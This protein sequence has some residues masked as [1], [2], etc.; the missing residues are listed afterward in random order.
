MRIDAGAIEI[1]I[2]LSEQFGIEE[3]FDLLSTLVE[4]AFAEHE[5][6]RQERFPQSV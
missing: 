5:V 2:Q 6:F 3:M 1:L 4:T